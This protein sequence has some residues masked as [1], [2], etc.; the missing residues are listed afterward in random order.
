MHLTSILDDD[1]VGF[2]VTHLSFT[3]MR[4]VWSH[5]FLFNIKTQ[6]I[7]NALFSSNCYMLMLIE[8]E[9]LVQGKVLGL[10]FKW[11]IQ[12]VIEWLIL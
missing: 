7:F 9:G 5:G 6:H 11:H 10:L 3:N 2:S 8:G 1:N 12:K 4:L